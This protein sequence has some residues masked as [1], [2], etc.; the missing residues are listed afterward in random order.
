MDQHEKEVAAARALF[1]G[2]LV[3]VEQRRLLLD[4]HLAIE[5]DGKLILSPCG[6][7]LARGMGWPSRD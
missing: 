1:E 6:G 5:Q 4:G 3:T 7:L 2:G